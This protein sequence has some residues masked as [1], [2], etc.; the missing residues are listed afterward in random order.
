[1]TSLSP[2]SSTALRR[3]VLVLGMHRSGTSAVTQ[4]LHLLGLAVPDNLI[5][6]NPREN[7][8]GF[9][10]SADIVAAH[11]D[12]LAAA[13]SDWDDPTPLPPTLFQ[14]TPARLCRERLER[15][16][17]RDLTRAP[18]FAIKDPR[19][20]RLVPLWLD[21]LDQLGIAP[22]VV[23]PVRHPFDIAASLAE[24]N[25]F[26][27]ARSL[28]LWL[29]HLVLAERHSRGLPRLLVDYAD[30]VD[31]PRQGARRLHRFLGLPDEPAARRLDSIA[32]AI[33]P[34]HR[35]H[36]SGDGAE[37]LPE[38][39]AAAYRAARDA[40]RGEPLDT[41]AM[42]QAGRFLDQAYG[43]FTETADPGALERRLSQQVTALT[44]LSA[45][46]A[47]RLVEGQEINRAGG[48]ID[49]IRLHPGGTVEI[50]G[51]AIDRRLGRA[52]S[53][54]ALLINGAAVAVAPVDRERADI[55]LAG[56][57]E[58]DRFDR[59]P[60]FT[61]FL[62]AAKAGEFSSC[63]TRMIAFG[64][65]GEPLGPLDWTPQAD[66]SLAARF[67][68][69]LAVERREAGQ[70]IEALAAERDR[71][72]AAQA[73]LEATLAT[74]RD[75][76]AAARAD[77]EAARAAHQDERAALLD[78]LDQQ[79]GDLAASRARHAEDHALLTRLR[80]DLA[81]VT[82]A[83]TTLAASHAALDRRFAALLADRQAMLTSTGWRIAR[84][85][86]RGG[87]LLPLAGRLARR[88]GRQGGAAR[89]ARMV[90]DSGLFD[91][92]AY[93]AANPDVEG[94][95]LD[96]FLRRGGAEGRDPSPAFACAA[97]AAAY[98]LPAGINPL[99]HH[100]R[101]C[102]DRLAAS[103]CFDRAFY[104]RSYPDVAHSRIDPVWHFLTRGWAEGRA[105]APGIDLAP[106][107]RTLGPETNLLLRL[108]AFLDAVATFGDALRPPATFAADWYLAH[109]PDVGGAGADPWRHYLRHGWREGRDP[110]P[111]FDT[112]WYLDR[113][114]DVR[115]A[116]VNPLLHYLRHGAAEGRDPHPLFDTRFYAEANRGE[117]DRAGALAHYLRI[118]RAEGRPT[119]PPRPPLA[120]P[121]ARGPRLLLILHGLGGGTERHCRDMA[122]LLAAEGAEPWLLRAER[123]ARM[124][125][126]EGLDGAPRVY[127]AAE[128]GEWAALVADL[129]ALRLDHL[130]LHHFIGFPPELLTLPAALG[131]DWDVTLHDYAWFCP[132]VTMVGADGRYCRRAETGEADCAACLAAAGPHA[133]IPLDPRS[134]AALAAWRAERLAVLAGARRLFV[135]D[136]DVAARVAA[137]A[138]GLP[139]AT[140]RPHPEPPRRIVPH[141]PVEGERIRVAVIGGISRDK[142][143]DLLLACAEAAERDRLPLAF[144]VIGTLS[145][146]GRARA[147]PNL[148]V[149]GAYRQEELAGLLRRIRCQ[150]AAFL[151]IWPETYCYTLSEALE[152]GLFPVVTDLGAPAR[153]VRALGWG[154]VI[155]PDAPPEAINRLLL[156]SGLSQPLPESHLRIGRDYPSLLGDYYALSPLPAP[157]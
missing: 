89:D 64:A 151:S 29:S 155:A 25:D 86:Q 111:M 23:L 123:S 15:I 72:A 63:N 3:A 22:V 104:L 62:S 131:L 49:T 118:G 107:R 50:G 144:E 76:L 67:E 94:D 127:H 98:R 114:P 31:D 2:L 27:R 56:E 9:W 157:V 77:L 68:A 132:R 87:R 130:H 34:R 140:V 51:W 13:G 152:A 135:P 61:L 26:A 80:A 81:T 150:V 19:M 37:S 109:N 113:H 125:L 16:L 95:P 116:G 129:R 30:F 45:Q 41:E 35:H 93:L 110:N 4:A 20:C 83:H 121:A 65:G 102:R 17:T 99:L 32:A 60:G 8:T 147:L 138:P 59:R 119:R 139:A 54:V 108:D 38:P 71:L 148:T 55:A 7:P 141:L 21:L 66:R 48:F 100:L 43:L 103:G 133:A 146:A 24:R 53:A 5:P 96:H 117:T 52:A 39:A 1:M 84:L 69:L 44:D 18:L 73:G 115:A 128:P 137:L 156:R 79:A 10:E 42:D 106:I 101:T 91:P 149:H 82:A 136:P 57:N 126:S 105:C 47:A 97:H 28:R 6:A 134:P 120:P 124:A 12:F 46:L 33:Q 85:L 14:G 88:R 11:Q 142:G 90:I 153:R 154:A 75:R 40:A 112:A 58:S 36:Q 143:R 78:R 122:A 74:E 92:A 70:R 145:E